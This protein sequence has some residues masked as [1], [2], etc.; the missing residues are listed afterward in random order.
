[1]TTWHVHINKQELFFLW[2]NRLRLRYLSSVTKPVA[3]AKLESMSVRQKSSC[4]EP[5]TYPNISGLSSLLFKGT[6]RTPQWSSGLRIH[7]PMQET[8]VPSLAQEYPTYHKATKPV[9]LN[10]WTCALEPFRCNK[11][12][13]GNEKPTHQN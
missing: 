8:Q 9:H 1:M 6:C 7:L 5:I 4:S 13:H 11:R 3:E 12:S 10:Y 2:Q